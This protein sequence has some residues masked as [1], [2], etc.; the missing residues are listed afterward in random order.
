MYKLVRSRRAHSGCMRNSFTRRGAMTGPRFSTFAGDRW[1][2]EQDIVLS[3]R[4]GFVWVSWPDTDAAVRLGSQEMVSAV[5]AD[6]LA[7]NALGESF[8]LHLPRSIE[9]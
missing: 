5:M 3:S 4:D 2:P 9:T 8:P 6:F 1:E 7:Q